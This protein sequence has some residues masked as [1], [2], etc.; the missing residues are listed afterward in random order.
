MAFRTLGVKLCF[1]SWGLRISETHALFVGLN[2]GHKRRIKN[3]YFAGPDLV[4]VYVPGGAE[5]GVSRASASRG[6]VRPN[7]YEVLGAPG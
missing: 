4:L 2:L 5:L 7:I 1:F 6:G 3:E